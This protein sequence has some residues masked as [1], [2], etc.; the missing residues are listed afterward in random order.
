MAPHSS[1]LAWRIPGTVEPGGLRSMGSHS[2][3]HDWSNLAAAAAAMSS[4]ASEYLEEIGLD[5]TESELVATKLMWWSE[6]LLH[7]RLSK[8]LDSTFRAKLWP[9]E[10]SINVQVFNLQEVLHY[11]INSTLGMDKISKLWC[12][13]VKWLNGKEE[14][15]DEMGVTDYPA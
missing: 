1:V 8:Y 9:P 13:L 6:G 2:V 12:S 7:H 14:F 11:F 15:E 5:H 10:R 4:R 3:R